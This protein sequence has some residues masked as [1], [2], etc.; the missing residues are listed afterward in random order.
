MNSTINK[1]FYTSSTESLFLRYRKVSKKAVKLGSFLQCLLH[2][3][4]GH[5]GCVWKIILKIL[6]NH[7]MKNFQIKLGQCGSLILHQN[8]SF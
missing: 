1:T 4:L 6:W 2:V 5:D 7:N 8:I 3:F